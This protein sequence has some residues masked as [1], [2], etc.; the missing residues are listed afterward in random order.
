[1][2]HLIV[3]SMLILSSV[4]VKAMADD[5]VQAT[6]GADTAPQCLTVQVDGKDT[7]ACF[8]LSDDQVQ[9]LGLQTEEAQESETASTEAHYGPRPGF[10]HYCET[11]CVR[12]DHFGRC[13]Q[14]RRFCW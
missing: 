13:I 5:Q 8:N 14:W 1:M 12:T 4:S 11:R 3:L 7:K 9:N 10:R 6:V 2:R